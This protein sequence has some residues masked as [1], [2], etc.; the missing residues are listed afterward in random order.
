MAQI[1][2]GMMARLNSGE[3]VRIVSV[4]ED[5]IYAESDIG[6]VPVRRDWI[7]ETYSPVEASSSGYSR[8]A[9]IGSEFADM[10][11]EQNANHD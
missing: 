10:E 2:T 8:L 3:V 4:S 9:M 5:G 7:N 11:K 1:E 6:I